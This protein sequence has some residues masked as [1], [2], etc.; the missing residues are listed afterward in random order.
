MTDYEKLTELERL[1]S[2][3]KGDSIP[4]KDRT[5]ECWIRDL[6]LRYKHFRL[7]WSYRNYCID[8]HVDQYGLCCLI[9]ALQRTINERVA[10]KIL[11]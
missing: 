10:K 6:A 3:G 4:I 7:R 2:L 11:S 5:T 9:S 8:V 1:Y